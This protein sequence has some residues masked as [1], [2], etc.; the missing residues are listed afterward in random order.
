M[1]K[2]IEEKQFDEAVLS[3]DR[4]TRVVAGGRRMRFRAVVVIGDRKGQIGLG[5]GKS[6]E[7]V[8][9]VDKATRKAKQ[10]LVRV[11][12]FNDTIPHDVQVKFKGSKI[13][14][15]PAGSGTGIIAGGVVRKILA[16]A[17]YKNILSKSFGSSNKLLNAQAIFMALQNL[18]MR[19][20]PKK[21]DAAP[22]VVEAETSNPEK[23]S[24][25]LRLTQ[26]LAPPVRK[27]RR[28]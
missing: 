4:V 19:A 8:G 2:N 24:T 10:N 23:K 9:A 26:K 18:T 28:N 21:K 11:H 14:L 3:I 5:T 7:V 15:L 27:E 17:G 25:K 1:R 22:A 12:I 6:N 16:L 20:E 13:L